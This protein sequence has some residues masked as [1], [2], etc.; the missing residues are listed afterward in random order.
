MHAIRVVVCVLALSIMPLLCAQRSSRFQFTNS[1]GPHA[2][3]LKVVAQYDYSRTYHSA[4]DE[5]GKPYTGERARPM[6][7]LVWYPAEKT[8]RKAWC[9]LVRK[10]K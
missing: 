6:Q 3:R 7:T 2:V 8:G 4:V 10:R 9:F 1:P 5:L